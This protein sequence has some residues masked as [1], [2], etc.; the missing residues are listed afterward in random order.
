MF[1][2]SADGKFKIK[3]NFGC[4]AGTTCCLQGYYG[5]ENICKKCPNERPS[6]PRPANGAP[7]EACKCPNKK[8]ES[9]F[10]CGRCEKF[11][12]KTGICQQ[13]IGCKDK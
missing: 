12:I 13:I 10:A 5:I 1:H 3:E 11:N 7:D 9:C 4:P 6:S 8:K 2:Y